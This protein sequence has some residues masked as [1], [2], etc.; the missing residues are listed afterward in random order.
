MK[1]IL[2]TTLGCLAVMIAHPSTAQALENDSTT[3]PVSI[4][5]PQAPPS[6]Q[7]MD[8]A[9]QSL[10]L[11]YKLSSREAGNKEGC[12]V[13][14]EVVGDAPFYAQPDSLKTVWV[15]VTSNCV[16]GVVA[17]YEFANYK[18]WETGEQQLRVQAL[19]RPGP[20]VTGSN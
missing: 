16:A 20:G 5:K 13:T 1:S 19:P 12:F 6:S 10:T 18:I 17:W 14:S 2:Y 7:A 11:T 8:K 15:R 4:L 3:I 9:L